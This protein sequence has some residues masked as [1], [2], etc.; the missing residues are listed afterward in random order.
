LP[1]IREISDEKR[2]S[3]HLALKSLPTSRAR[4]L[5]TLLPRWHR[6]PTPN[7][8]A[9]RSGSA[10]ADLGVCDNGQISPD[11][12]VSFLK[13]ETAEAKPWIE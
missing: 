1:T 13:R 12:A 4:I 9:I 5:L 2:V 7:A 10:A 3:R 6:I 11:L 8:F